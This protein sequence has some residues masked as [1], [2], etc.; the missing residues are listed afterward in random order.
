MATIRQRV[1]SLEPGVLVELFQAAIP[2][3]PTFF[4]HNYPK[5]G[6]GT[7]PFQ[8]AS[9][10]AWPIQADG[11]EYGSD[12]SL[13]RP[14]LRIGDGNGVITGLMLAY[15]DLIGTLVTRKRTLQEYLDDQP[16]A[17]PTQEYP[18]DIYQVDNIQ[19]AVPG[20]AIEFE[21][22]SPIDNENIM[23]PGRQVKANACDWVLFGPDCGYT[24]APKQIENPDGSITALGTVTSQ[25]LYNSGTTYALNDYVY[26]LS[27]SGLKVK[28]VSKKNGNTDPLIDSDS[29]ALVVCGKRVVD[30]KLHFGDNAVLNTSA[31][32]AVARLPKTL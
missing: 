24:G 13:P 26:T 10:V 17:D 29:W 4:F 12:G 27:A 20:Q 8:S 1:Q 11:W 16:G 18:P 23:L 9:Y 3:G 28:W 32:P 14:R 22:I 21:L 15:D 30:C 5:D 19:S 2:S 31:F 7:I 25:G 6:D